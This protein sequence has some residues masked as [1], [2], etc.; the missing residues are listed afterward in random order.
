M[1]VSERSP[2][3]GACPSRPAP[4]KAVGHHTRH[5][6]AGIAAA[7]VLAQND[8]DT[9][10]TGPA[11]DIADE[12]NHADN[13]VG[14]AASIMP[15]SSWSASVSTA[16]AMVRRDSGS[17]PLIPREPVRLPKPENDEPCVHDGTFGGRIFTGDFGR[18]IESVE[19]IN[20]S[21]SSTVAGRKCRLR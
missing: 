6:I 21:R 8:L 13:V 14:G 9:G 3:Y 1:F 17:R 5:G 16:H 20:R 10:G 7:A 2:R 4:G 18:A 12:E 15:P 19:F 11:I